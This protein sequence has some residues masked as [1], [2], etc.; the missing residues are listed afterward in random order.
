MKELIVVEGKNDAQVIRRAL[1]DVEILWTDGF[2]LT[3]AALQ[4]IAQAAQRQG[5]IV[6]TD[7]DTAGEHIR[8]R[9]RRAV[10]AAKHLYLSQQAAGKAGDI[11][12]ENASPEEIR[13]LFAHL[14]QAR[15][16]D[17]GSQ[18]GMAEVF[19]LPDLLAYGLAGCL[20]AAERRRALGHTLGLGDANAKTLLARLNRLGVGRAELAEALEEIEHGK[21]A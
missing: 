15:G 4:Y 11:G 21:R 17:P 10:P 3:E 9:I 6:L 13:R 7:P 16:N 1:G 14:R 20:G 19:T 5:V 12:V 8:A 2:G 18:P